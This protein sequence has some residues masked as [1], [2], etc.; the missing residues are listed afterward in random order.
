MEMT[1]GKRAIDKIYRRRDRYEI[2]DWQ[3]TEVWNDRKKRT[4]IDSILKDW[5]LPKFY[6]QLIDD[7]PE[8]YE[9]VDGQQRL[10][11][12]FEFFDGE[13]SLPAS[14]EQEFGGT[15]YAT[16]SDHYRDA[17]DDFEIEIDIVMDADETEIKEFFQ[18]L[19]AG[20]PLTSSENLNAIHSN[21][22]DFC[23]SLSAHPFFTDKVWL[24]DKRY[25]HFDIAAKVAALELDGI[26][27]GLRFEDLRKTFE[28]QASFS[29]QSQAAKRLRSTFDYLNRVFP[30]RNAILRN[31]TIV[32]SFATFAGRVVATGRA[33]GRE[34]T[35]RA[36]FEKFSAELSRQIELGSETTDRDYI[37]FQKSVNANIRSGPKNRQAIL[38]RKILSFDP[39]FAEVFEPV[40]LIEAGLKKQISEVAARIQSGVAQAN[41]RYA[42][43]SGQDLFKA[44]NKTTGALLAIGKPIRR[45]DEYQALIDALYFLTHESV[46]NRLTGRVPQ[47]FSDVVE[48]R[49]D[50]QHD[51]DHGSD[52]KA[53]K[54]RKAVAQAFRKYAGAGTPRTLDPSR[55]VVVQ[56]NLL[57]DIA[58]DIESIVAAGT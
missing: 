51:L 49:T 22:R 43:E 53:A 10:S 11:A 13:L 39:S 28:S 7:N 30:E 5:K 4:L 48:L 14:A 12:I 46:G 3:R 19:Q 58:R 55:F 8:Q 56:G 17:F 36:F 47:S 32:Q 18:R 29:S 37:D 23:R 41:E 35:L 50:L 33:S 44:T 45:Y 15:K 57:R 26:E 9:V 40:D 25:A 2:P 31:R 52:K 21:L 16:I 34:Q 24:A 42:A 38:L 6:F 54:R 1:S 27:T 20:L